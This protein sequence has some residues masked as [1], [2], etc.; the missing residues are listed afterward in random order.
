M[1]RIPHDS[2]DHKETIMRALALKPVTKNHR[3]GR[4]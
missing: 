3:K 2:H 4:Q 1:S